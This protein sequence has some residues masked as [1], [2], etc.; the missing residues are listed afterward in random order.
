VELSYSEK[1][2]DP[3][4]TTVEPLLLFTREEKATWTGILGCCRCAIAC[5]K[6][7]LLLKAGDNNKSE[8]RRRNEAN[9]N[10]VSEDNNLVD[11]PFERI[12]RE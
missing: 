5:S 8:S 3:A 4:G 12:L 11:G 2:F 6:I 1:L 9:K 7:P 10:N